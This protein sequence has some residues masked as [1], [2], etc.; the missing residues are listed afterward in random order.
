MVTATSCM[1]QFI[2]ALP[3]SRP[4][5]REITFSAAYSH[6]RFKSATPTWQQHLKT[7]CCCCFCCFSTAFSRFAVYRHLQFVSNE[8]WVQ[9]LNTI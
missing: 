6:S 8:N 7:F 3:A 4:A 5:Q 9:H 1:W 2:L